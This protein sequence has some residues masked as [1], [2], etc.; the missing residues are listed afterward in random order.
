LKPNQKIAVMA[1]DH[2]TGNMGIAEVTV[3]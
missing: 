2:R 1:I 3:K